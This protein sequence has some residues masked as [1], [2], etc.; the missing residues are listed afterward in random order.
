[1]F[2]CTLLVR[3]KNQKYENDLCL[4]CSDT[5]ENIRFLEFLAFSYIL[6]PNFTGTIMSNL[7]G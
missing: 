1:M 3:M 5:N 6:K 2:A 7:A 4:N